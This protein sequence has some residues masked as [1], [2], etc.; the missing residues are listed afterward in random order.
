MN[1]GI[2]GGVK[3]ASR[4]DCFAVLPTAILKNINL[5]NVKKVIRLSKNNIV[6]LNINN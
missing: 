4:N 5:K 3:E 2:E 6:M 1:A